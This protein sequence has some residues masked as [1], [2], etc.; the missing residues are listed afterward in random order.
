MA[1]RCCVFRC[2]VSDSLPDPTE[3]P[4][5]RPEPLKWA[6]GALTANRRRIACDLRNAG[7]SWAKRS[8]ENE[9]LP[10][11]QGRSETKR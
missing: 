3:L 10:W 4:G 11:R 9:S 2:I 6:L 5:L 8:W 1:C 7:H